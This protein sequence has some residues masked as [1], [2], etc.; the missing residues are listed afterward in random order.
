MRWSHGGWAE[1]NIEDGW[2]SP[3]EIV[4]WHIKLCF[5]SRDTHGREIQG[6]AID[7]LYRSIEHIVWIWLI[8]CAFYHYERICSLVLYVLLLAP[9]PPSLLSLC[10]SFHA[11]RP[12]SVYTYILMC[13]AY[14]QENSDDWMPYS[15][16]NSCVIS[17]HSNNNIALTIHTTRLFI[18]IQYKNPFNRHNVPTWWAPLTWRTPRSKTF[19]ISKI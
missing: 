12:F 8:C 1:R 13:I 14:I 4:I 11:V 7:I 6:Y 5:L 17:Y 16:L 10:L 15:F 18:L 3:L 9:P 19:G 2:K